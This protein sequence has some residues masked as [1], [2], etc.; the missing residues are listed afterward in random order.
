MR[1][2]SLDEI[3]AATRIGTRF[4]EALEN[5]EWDRLPGG[6]FNRGFVRAVARFL[7]LDEDGLVAEYALAM[8]EHTGAPVSMWTSQSHQQLAGHWPANPGANWPLRIGLLIAVVFLAGAGWLGWRRYGSPRPQQ[9]AQDSAPQTPSSSDPAASAKWP[10]DPSATSATSPARPAPDPAPR[11]AGIAG[12]HPESPSA[13]TAT[14][15]TSSGATSSGAAPSAATATLPAPP[16]APSGPPSGASAA[17]TH[18]TLPVAPPAEISGLQLKIA[19]SKPTSVT[20]A[21]DGRQVF[22][23]TIVAG[24]SRTFSARN[25]IAV[26]AQDAGAVSLEL[27]GQSVPAMGRAGHSARIALTRRD[28]KAAGGPD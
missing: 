4:L 26:R 17:G 6:V 23:A 15:A 11:P 27:N 19:A 21:A 25:R 8:S 5:E 22:R 1:G 10:D 7:G 9:V 13:A 24:Q 14:G 16:G 2:V 20:V 18:G 12:A 3:C 28:L